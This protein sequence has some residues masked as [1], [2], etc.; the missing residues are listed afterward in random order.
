[1]GSFDVVD[2][3]ANPYTIVYRALPAVRAAFGV[4]SARMVPVLQDFSIRLDY[5]RKQVAAQIQAVAD[6]CLGDFV[7]WDPKVTYVAR[8]LPVGAPV[9]SADKGC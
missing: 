8:S 5:G 9:P 2:P 6:R 3:I 7:L 4:S 1:M